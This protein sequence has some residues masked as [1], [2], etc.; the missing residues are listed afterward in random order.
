MERTEDRRE[1]ELIDLGAASVET[2]GG[3]QL[4]GEATG[5]L[6]PEGISDD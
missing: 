2:H 4:H 1:A 6:L 3:V 5:Y